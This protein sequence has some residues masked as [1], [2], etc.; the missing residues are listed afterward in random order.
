M[1][2]AMVSRE[3]SVR[4]DTAGL[5]DP[6]L[7]VRVRSPFFAVLV[8]ALAVLIGLAVYRGITAPDDTRWALDVYAT[9]W[10]LAVL[11]VLLCIGISLG[12]K[13]LK[14]LARYIMEGGG[15]T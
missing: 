9:V 3:T 11:L 2:F 8:C 12:S 4:S 13:F 14:R 5:S 1:S 6:P 15:W 7:S 10:M